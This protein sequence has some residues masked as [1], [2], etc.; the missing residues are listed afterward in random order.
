[1]D[2]LVFRLYG[3]KKLICRKIVW[4]AGL[5]VWSKIVWSKIVPK[6]PSK[7][8]VQNSDFVFSSPIFNSHQSDVKTHFSYRC[9]FFGNTPLHELPLP[10][11]FL[12]TFLDAFLDA[13]LDT[14]LDTQNRSKSP[15]IAR[16][17]SKSLK[18]A[19]NHSKSLK[20]AQNRSKSLEIAYKSGSCLG[21]I[22]SK[23][24]FQEFF[25]M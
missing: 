17:R 12:D 2:T 22:M 20:I 3:Q 10:D 6:K 14:F 8:T 24:I 13:F 18:I 7:K 23:S 15:E 11:T 5:F 9:S 19:Q 1:L 16:N 4:L 21:L 25:F